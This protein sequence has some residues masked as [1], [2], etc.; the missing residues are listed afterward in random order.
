MSDM[1]KLDYYIAEQYEYMHEKIKE[2]KF[3]EFSE[4][5]KK[6]VESRTIELEAQRDFLA[7]TLRKI[8]AAYPCTCTNSDLCL[9]CGIETALNK[10]D[11]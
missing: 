6:A 11:M 1:T 7:T 9:K 10:V 8:K 4:R 5:I 3:K 2:F